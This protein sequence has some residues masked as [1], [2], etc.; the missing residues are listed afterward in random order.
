VLNNESSI[1][2]LIWWWLVVGEDV[3]E[4]RERLDFYGSSIGKTQVEHK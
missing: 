2:E 4:G 1:G 3:N